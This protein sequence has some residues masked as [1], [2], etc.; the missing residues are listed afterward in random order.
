MERRSSDAVTYQ[1]HFLRNRGFGETLD[2]YS[3]AVEENASV[4]RCRYAFVVV[5]FVI[6]MAVSL[7]VLA[8][9]VGA[10]PPSPKRW[11]NAASSSEDWMACGPC[12]TGGNPTRRCC[13]VIDA[14]FCRDASKV[15]LL[16][17]LLH[18]CGLSH[19]CLL[20]DRNFTRIYV[21]V[22]DMPKVATARESGEL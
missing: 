1:V 22:N 14:D 5:L 15:C 8:F 4:T 16:I 12:G 9:A 13:A 18:R 10:Q 21:S 2:V 20:G 3:A 6:N 11:R 17:P 19:G 7:I